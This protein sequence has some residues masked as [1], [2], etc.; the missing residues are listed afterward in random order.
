MAAASENPQNWRFGAFEVEGRTAELRRNGVAIRLQ[1]QPSQLLLYMLQHAGEIVTREDLRA[2]LWPADTFVDFDHALNTAVMKLREALGDSSDKPLYIQTLPRKGYRF[3]APVSALP[4]S[5]GRSTASQ[6]EEP[7]SKETSPSSTKGNPQ[8]T[9]SADTTPNVIRAAPSLADASDTSG[10]LHG[11][12]TNKPRAR[13]SQAAVP[14]ISVILGAAILLAA[15]VFFYLRGKPAIA[16]A[17]SLTRITFDEGLQ[18]DPTWSPDGRYIAYSANRGGVTNIWMQQISVGEPIQI[19]AGPGPNWQPDW[20]PD[21]RYIAYRSDA[22]E[23]GLFVIPALGGA[24]QERRIATFGYNPHW[25]PDGSQ[26]L[27]QSTPIAW[28]DINSFYVVGLDGSPPHQVFAEFFRQHSSFYPLSA[29]WHP[30]GKR[31]TIWVGD[32]FREGPSPVF[33]TL[34]LDGGTPLHSEIAPQIQHRF[35]ELSVRTGPEPVADSKFVWAPTGRALYLE[36]TFRGARNIWRLNIDPSTLR[37]T[38]S[39]QL[40]AGAGFASAPAIS[41]DG[42]KLAVTAANYR[43]SAWLYPLDA[44]QGR[45]TGPGTPVTSPGVDAWLTATTRDGS[46]LAF[47][48]VRAGETHLWVK[49]L[50]DGSELPLFLDSYVRDGPHWS[51]DEIR[52]AYVRFPQNSDEGQIMVWS[53]ETRQEEPVTSLAQANSATTSPPFLHVYGWSPDGRSLLFTK[54]NSDGTDVTVWQVPMS[55]APHAELQERKIIADPRFSIYQPQFSPDGKWIAFEAVS[56]QNPAGPIDR[57]SSLYVMP[58][59]GGPWIPVIDDGSW[60][61][62]P[63]WSPDGRILYFLWRHDSFLNVWGIHFNPQTGRP[64]GNPFRVTSL[65]SPDL[66]V[67]SHIGAVEIS[68]S[69]KSLV[70]T[71][72]QISGGIWVLD[73][74]DR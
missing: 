22:S 32:H 29:A 17:R 10:D 57:A 52:L 20:S 24:G 64:V 35:A 14:R 33:W 74:V 67:P 16:P 15:A 42:K 72:R 31:V 61:D 65:K 8:G 19:T 63:R 73:N 23:D 30:D 36:Q 3:V 25:S 13:L 45:I 70:T 27:F 62:K 21:G 59:A 11:G 68:I 66:M 55:A 9:I 18:S 48:G 43:I 69:S 47:F 71:L 4:A 46:K 26:I 49:S 39:E 37:A 34:P 40:T 7:A 53:A 28:S 58:A 5:N 51:P 56:H 44:D 54:A 60:A 38:G 1:E 50:P 2:Q 41:P 12:N 6:A